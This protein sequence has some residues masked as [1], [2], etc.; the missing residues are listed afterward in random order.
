MPIV[1]AAVGD[2]VYFVIDDKPKATRTGLRRLRN[3][4]ENPQ[5]ALLVDDY[6]EDWSAL[7]YLLVHGRAAVV[8]DGEEYGR[9]LDALRDRYP[10][11]R[12]MPLA[13]DTHPMVRIACERS[14]LWQATPAQPRSTLPGFSQSS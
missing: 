12:A 1:Y 13:I 2:N 4:A 8:D 10:R 6:D 3:I 9:I 11:Y 5:V 14:H 7:A